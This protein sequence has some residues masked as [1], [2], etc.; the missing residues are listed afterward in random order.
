[1]RNWPDKTLLFSFHWCSASECCHIHNELTYEW[2]CWIKCCRLVRMMRLISYVCFRYTCSC[3]LWPTCG[4]KTPPVCPFSSI[5]RN[6][7][8]TFVVYDEDVDDNVIALVDLMICCVALRFL[9]W[10]VVT[11]AE[12]VCSVC[13]ESACCTVPKPGPGPLQWA[14]V[15]PQGNTK[16]WLTSCSTAGL[17]TCIVDSW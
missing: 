5:Y 13:A 16:S 8:K 17:Q 14:H 1:M 11:A 3:D 10:H 4:A 9:P 6:H 7:K 15:R 12:L 2:V